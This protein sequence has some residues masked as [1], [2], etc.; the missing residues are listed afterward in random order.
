VNQLVKLLSPPIL[1]DST[2]FSLYAITEV[3]R[4]PKHTL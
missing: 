1:V 3:S 4:K 2:R